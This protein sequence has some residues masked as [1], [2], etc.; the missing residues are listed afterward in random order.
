MIFIANSGHLIY[1]KIRLAFAH[2]ASMNLNAQNLYANSKQIKFDLVLFVCKFKGRI[3]I[4]AM[5]IDQLLTG[6]ENIYFTDLQVMNKY[7]KILF[8]NDLIK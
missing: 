4:K 8:F 1:L 5:N 3:L 7:F 2:I 6:H